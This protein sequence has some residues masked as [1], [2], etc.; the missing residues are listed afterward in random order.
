MEATIQNWA[1]GSPSAVIAKA[2]AS[3]TGGSIRAQ[4][5]SNEL[6]GGHLH[7]VP[8]S[9]RQYV[10]PSVAQKAG[11]ITRRV[12]TYLLKF[13]SSSN[14]SNAW[15][16]VVEIVQNFEILCGEQRYC[17]YF[18]CTFQ[19]HWRCPATSRGF[20]MSPPTPSSLSHCSSRSPSL[21]PPYYTCAWALSTIAVRGVR[22]PLTS[23]SVDLRHPPAV[24]VTAHYHAVSGFQ[25]SPIAD[26]L[27]GGV[28]TTYCQSS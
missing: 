10:S 9:R 18:F 25:T 3:G 19:W 22:P 7:D 21:W 4:R 13:N 6:R 1:S 11:S 2:S 23:P 20:Q 28:I 14:T 27:C 5:L 16:Y 8:T 12:L 17:R 26:I 15:V 24:P